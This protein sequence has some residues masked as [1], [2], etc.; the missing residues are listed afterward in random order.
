MRILRATT[1]A[2]AILTTAVTGRADDSL[3][4]QIVDAMN[5]VY[6]VHPGFR[7]NHAKGIVAEG[8]FE[9]APEASK[10]SVSPLFSSGK[11]PVTVRFSDAGGVPTVPDLS[12]GANPH[13]LAVK[14]HLAGGDTDMVTN[15]LKTFPVATGEEFR[16][17]HLAIAASPPDAPKPTPLDTFIASHPSVPKALGSVGIPGSFADEEYHGVNA[18]VFSNAAGQKQA[19]RYVISPEKLVHL[20]AEDAAKLPPDYLA[21]ELQKRLAKGPVTFQLKAQ[22]A[23]PSDPTRDA[24]QAWPD[25]RPIAPLGVLTLTKADP[26]SAE[27]QKKLLFLPTLLTDG[28]APSDDPL[29]LLRTQ[30]Y[31]ISFARRSAPPA[32]HP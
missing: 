20:S 15:S 22:L 13:G 30:A 24:T 32:P 8:S 12:P 14:F 2:A 3:A 7:A 21:D 31:I 26:D 16:D 28:I 25:D 9:P 27:A 11:V 19:V 10:L 5:K 17:L 29:I 23:A 1:L 6:G 18:F 4:V